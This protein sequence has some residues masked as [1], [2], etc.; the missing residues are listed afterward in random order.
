M[1]D[2]SAA[3]RISGMEIPVSAA[4]DVYAPLIEWALNIVVSMPA[5]D[6]TVFIH[7]ATMALVAGPYGF[8]DVRNTTGL[9]FTVSSCLN[10]LVLSQ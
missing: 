1:F 4:A 10:P 2:Q 7:L 3:S 6:S 9:F 5:L 8:V